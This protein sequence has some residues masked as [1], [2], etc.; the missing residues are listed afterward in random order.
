M[1]VRTCQVVRGL[2]PLPR[3]R[4][5]VPIC[6]QRLIVKGR[7]LPDGRMVFQCGL[8][9]GSTVHVVAQRRRFAGKLPPNIWSKVV[10]FVPFDEV[11]ASV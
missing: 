11:F 9:E 1:F 2:L 4:S 7:Q 5:G 8:A 6:N 3:C 10:D